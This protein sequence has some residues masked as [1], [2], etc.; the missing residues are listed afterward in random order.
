MNPL[1]FLF[2]NGTKTD[3]PKNIFE[4]KLIGTKYVKVLN[5]AIG[6]E[7]STYIK[8]IYSFAEETLIFIFVSNS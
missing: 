1:I 4:R 6:M 8:N 5:R 2:L 3:C 7:T